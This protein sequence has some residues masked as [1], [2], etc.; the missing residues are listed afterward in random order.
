MVSNL[1]ILDLLCFAVGPQDLPAIEAI[2][3]H[4][5]QGICGKGLPDQFP[6]LGVIHEV[7]VLHPV[8]DQVQGPLDEVGEFGIEL[9]VILVP[10]TR[11]DVLPPGL[12][13]P[14]PDGIDVH[15]GQSRHLG[16][17]AQG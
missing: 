10:D 8:L 6:L 12:H 2:R 16:G 11:L 9:E 13:L 14:G 7:P 17:I 3:Q 5:I 1:Y 4:L 15:L